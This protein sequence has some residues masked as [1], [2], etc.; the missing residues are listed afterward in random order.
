[1]IVSSSQTVSST[2]GVIRE[3]FETARQSEK[4]FFADRT[5][6]SQSLRFLV[7]P[8]VQSNSYL[9]AVIMGHPIDVIQKALSSLITMLGVVFVVFLI[10]V[11]LGGY[12][13]ARGAV[14]PISAISAKL[15][16]INSGNLDERI[17]NPHT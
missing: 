14:A 16:Q 11:V 2:D 12:L 9:G 5:I 17:D 4:P 1:M 10:P 13:N 15:K 8:I 3:L 6:G 7:T